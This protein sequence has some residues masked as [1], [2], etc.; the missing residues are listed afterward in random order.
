[1]TKEKYFVAVDGG[2]EAERIFFDKE[3]AIANE[4]DYIDSFDSNGLPVSSYK[5]VENKD[6]VFEYTG[7]F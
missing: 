5:I 4:S 1:M 6:G 3:L 2:G 7:D